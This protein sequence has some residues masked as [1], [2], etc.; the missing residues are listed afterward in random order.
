MIK[1]IIKYLTT[2]NGFMVDIMSKNWL[3]SAKND[4]SGDSEEHLLYYIDLILF[5]PMGK[6]LE[7]I[8]YWTQILEST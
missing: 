1:S 4:L 3:A 8:K 7:K 6:I 2:E 5:N